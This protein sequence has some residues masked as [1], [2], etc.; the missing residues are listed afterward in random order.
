MKRPTI[1]MYKG[2]SQYD[3]LRHFVDQLGMG[4]TDFDYDV[5]II[6]LLEQATWITQ[7]EQVLVDQEN[8][9]FFCSFNGIGIDLTLDNGQK[10]HEAIGVP[11]FSIYV[12]HPI[13]HTVRILSQQ[14]QGKANLNVMSFV[15]PRHSEFAAKQFSSHSM[16]MFLPHAS[17]NIEDSIAN[18]PFEQR[19]IDISVSGSYL[20]PAVTMASWK[21]GLS[22]FVYGVL[23]EII[24]ISE[25]VPQYSVFDC[26]EYW[27]KQ[28]GI[29]LD[30]LGGDRTFRYVQEVDRFLR[31]SFRHKV[32]DSLEG[33]KLHVCGA[34]WEHYKNDQVDVIRHG[35]CDYQKMREMM[36]NS[37][38]VVN[39]F[40]TYNQWSH[41]R[42]FDACALGAVALTKSNPYWNEV[43]KHEHNILMFEDHDE[44][45]ELIQTQ[46]QQRHHLEQIA[47]NGYELVKLQHQWRNR[48]SQVLEAV[49]LAFNFA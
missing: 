14:Q 43:F 5:C 31:Q 35:A 3:V 42:V 44:L 29:E 24:E 7:L 9:V 11:F 40:P 16:K 10:I 46:L 41:E 1:V 22:P 45:K 28:R 27:T 36:N 47:Q 17:Y 6:D 34:G 8:I 33:C 30:A 26:W 12:D 13:Y 20:D 37:K 25:A 15:D 19:T 23:N 2:Q 32:I 39:A 38:I 49:F 4:F 48:A 18:I 21:E